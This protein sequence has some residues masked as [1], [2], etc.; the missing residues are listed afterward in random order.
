MKAESNC[1]IIRK[2]IRLQYS[3]S[4]IVF[5]FIESTAFLSYHNKISISMHYFLI[6]SLF[7]SGATMTDV[8]SIVLEVVH[9][10]LQQN[11]KK[12]PVR[13]A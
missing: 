3:N 11:K 12:L 5:S 9:I 13:S 8:F 2:S 1:C 4:F 10:F 7:Q 6:Q